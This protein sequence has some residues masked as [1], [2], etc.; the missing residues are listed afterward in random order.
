MTN[1]GHLGAN[2]A[3]LVPLASVL[4][5]R[6]VS[7]LG[8]GRKG[9]C[10]LACHRTIHNSQTPSFVET[11]FSSSGKCWRYALCSEFKE[12]VGV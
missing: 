7:C 6:D 2:G 1:R 5:I 10:L 11:E 12:L 8:H 9:I 4:E 3:H